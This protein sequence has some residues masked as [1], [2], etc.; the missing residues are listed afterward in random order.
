MGALD[1]WAG[2]TGSTTPGPGGWAFVLRDT[3]GDELVSELEGSGGEPATTGNRMQLTAVI[4]GLRSLTRPGAVEV[5]LGSTYVSDAFVGGTID[6]W[7]ARGF[8]RRVGGGTASVKHADLW[9]ELYSLSVIHRLD[10]TPGRGH[11]GG[12]VHR[13]VDRLAAAGREANAGAV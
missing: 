10:W 7:V 13:R 4:E 3:D 6:L 9:Q 1:L 5:H 8:K 2:A 11:A 12:A